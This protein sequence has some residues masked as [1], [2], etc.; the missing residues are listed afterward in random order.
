MNGLFES[1]NTIKYYN[2]NID[3]NFNVFGKKIN[4]TEMAFYYSYFIFRFHKFYKIDEYSRYWMCILHE[5]GF[6][7]SISDNYNGHRRISETDIILKI[8]IHYSYLIYRNYPKKLNY[9]GTKITFEHNGNI[10]Y[11]DFVDKILLNKL[12]ISDKYMSMVSRTL[13]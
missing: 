4:K 1:Y 9:W 7:K 6:V 5:N 3:N 2:F 10:I 8:N 13:L 11:P 12:I